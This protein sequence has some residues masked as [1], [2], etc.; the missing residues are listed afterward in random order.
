MDRAY[1]NY[2]KFEELTE[3]NVVYVTK[4]KKNL[5]YEVLVDCMDMNEDGLMEYRE[6]VIEGERRL[7]VG[8]QVGL[9][10]RGDVDNGVNPPLLHLFAGFG[11]GGIPADDFHL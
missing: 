3:R 10:S 2:E 11:E 6:Q 4:M 9:E 7:P 8:K 1:I 5:K